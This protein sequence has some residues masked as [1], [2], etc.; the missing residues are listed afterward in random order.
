MRLDALVSGADT[1]PLYRFET[2]VHGTTRLLANEWAGQGINVNAHA[3]RSIQPQQHPGAAQMKSVG[4]PRRIPLV[5]GERRKTSGAGPSR[6]ISG[7]AMCW[8]YAG[9]RWRMAGAESSGDKICTVTP[10]PCCIKTY[11]VWIGSLGCV[12]ADGGKAISSCGFWGHKPC[13][14][15]GYRRVNDTAGCIPMPYPSFSA[16][17]SL[18]S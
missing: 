2:G 6:L 14:K 11:T 9:R 13:Q 17:D 10:L 1:V 8:L 12:I 7:P 16:N 15:H 4:D 5:A 3:P 18:L